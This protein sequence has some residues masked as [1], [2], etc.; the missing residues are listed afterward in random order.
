MVHDDRVPV[1]ATRTPMK[2][3][4]MTTTLPPS[5]ETWEQ[6]P[7]PPAPPAPPKRR[8]F[9]WRSD[10]PRWQIIALFGVAVLVGVGIGAPSGTTSADDGSAEIA[11]LERTLD[12]ERDQNVEYRAQ[13]D[14][15]VA[16]VADLR[17]QATATETEFAQRSADLDARETALD[18]RAT[19]LDTREGQIAGAEAAAE[20]NSFGNGI[21][22]VGTDIQPGT[23][24]SDGPDSSSLGMGYW[25]RLSGL[26]GTLDE[27]ISNDLPSGP[28]TVTISPSDVA[29]ESTGMQTWTK[30][31]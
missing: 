21:H 12:V 25:A 22:V 19:G 7:A 17:D 10:R 18:E 20:A 30:I 1:V 6:P 5:F 16:Q 4:K 11:S 29:F 13:R 9:G 31:D 2:G 28:T 15:A 23:Y 27:I 24:K 3:S 8:F 14:D 26:G